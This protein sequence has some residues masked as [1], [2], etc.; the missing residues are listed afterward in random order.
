MQDM[1]VRVRLE[2]SE[3]PLFY[4]APYLS[5]ALRQRLVTLHSEG[6]K[7]AVD[8]VYV[9]KE[10]AWLWGMAAAER[11]AAIQCPAGSAEKSQHLLRAACWAAY[12]Q[13]VEAAQRGYDTLLQAWA[14]T[15]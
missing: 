6:D 4:Y 3:G 9:W 2:T 13:A 5:A 8:T 14:Y 7:V 15:A 11:L 12:V 1:I 10:R